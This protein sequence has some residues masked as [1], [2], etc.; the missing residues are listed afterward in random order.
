MY[1]L[2]ACGRRRLEQ[3]EVALIAEPWFETVADAR[4]YA[5]RWK[6]G[7]EPVRLS[8]DWMRG[9]ENPDGLAEELI[10]SDGL[11]EEKEEIHAAKV[12]DLVKLHRRREQ[13]RADEEARK[14]EEARQERAAR[15]KEKIEERRRRNMAEYQEMQQV[16][17][18][19]SEQVGRDLRKIST[20]PRRGRPSKEAK[21]AAKEEEESSDA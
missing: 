4:T 17:A 13:E 12:A 7:L 11:A 2:I 3:H 16:V 10:L 8:V 5:L 21:R 15:A 18:E 6:H 14:Q 1:R 19:A 20:K 9:S